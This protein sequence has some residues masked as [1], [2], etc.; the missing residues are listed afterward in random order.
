MNVVMYV[1]NEEFSYIDSLH[2]GIMWPDFL[3]FLIHK[4]LLAD[5]VNGSRGEFT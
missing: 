4:E 2:V 3:Q 1:V 5:E